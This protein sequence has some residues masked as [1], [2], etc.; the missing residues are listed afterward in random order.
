M[1]RTHKKITRKELKQDPL[2]IF[3]A[4]VV[5]YLQNEWI[6]LVSIIVSV[7]VIVALALFIVK[8]KS[9]SEINAYDIALRAYNSDAPE[10][11]DL[12][13]KFVDTYSGSKRAPEILIQLGNHFFAQKNYDSA[14]KYYLHYTEKFSD[15]P[16]Y[17]FNAYTGLGGVYEEKGDYHNAGEIYEEFIE[18]YKNSPFITIM[19]LN[20]GKAYYLAGEKDA[21]LRNFNIIIT[22]YGDSEE[23][24][25][26]I[27]YTELLQSDSA[28]M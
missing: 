11:V 7:I 10:A 17:G 16:I 6:K 24:Y 18:H 1:L 26:A 14:E 3:I 4:Q 8:G 28:G 5:E 27:Y 12:L 13:K 20:A 9:R 23:I 15:D 22:I 25:D 2:V 19:Y 21:A